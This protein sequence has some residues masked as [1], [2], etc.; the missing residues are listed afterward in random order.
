MLVLSR[1]ESEA[2]VIDDTIRIKVLSVQGKTVRLGIE[3]PNDVRI[4]R[5]ELV[6]N[7]ATH[8][9]LSMKRGEWT[10]TTRHNPS[11]INGRWSPRRRAG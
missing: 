2:I 11:R 7:I 9:V 8:E 6:V 3:A 10:P 1:R 5:A 4:M